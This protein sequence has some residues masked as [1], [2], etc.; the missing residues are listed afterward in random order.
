MRPVA[1]DLN[2]RSLMPQL[3]GILRRPF[4]DSS[5]GFLLL[6]GLR[7]R[8]LHEIRFRASGLSGT[9]PPGSLWAQRQL[10]I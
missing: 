9:R 5:H 4:P 1:R 2:N 3:S 6:S 8:V 10:Q 7:C